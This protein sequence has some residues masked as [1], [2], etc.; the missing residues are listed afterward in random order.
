ML[1]KYA[2]AVGLLLSP[3]LALAQPTPT[4]NAVQGGPVTKPVK[5]QRSRAAAAA[6][7]D[8]QPSGTENG[9]QPD[10][11]QAGGGSR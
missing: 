7:A 4:R 8:K 2:L 9:N 11:A 3:M 10:R 6:R 5:P 1:L